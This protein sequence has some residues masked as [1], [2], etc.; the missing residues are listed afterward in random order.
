MNTGA[1]NCTFIRTNASTSSA[2][3]TIAEA[4]VPIVYMPWATIPGNPAA[5]ATSSS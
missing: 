1:R 5:R 4:S 2:H 3:P